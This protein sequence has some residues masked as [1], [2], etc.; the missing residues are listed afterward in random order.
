MLPGVFLVILPCDPHADGRL[1]HK[2][3]KDEFLPRQVDKLS[4]VISVHAGSQFHYAVTQYKQ[5][6]FWGQAKMTGEA[7]TYPKIVHDLSGWAVRSLACGPTSTMLCAGESVISWG[8][9]PAFGELGYGDKEQRRGLPVKTSPKPK[10]VDCLEGATTL[11]VRLGLQFS[12]MVVQRGNDAGDAVLD[13]L[14]VLEEED[15]PVEADSGGGGKGGKAGK[16]GK[17]GK[18]KPAAA[19]KKRA[20]PA[21]KAAKSKTRKRK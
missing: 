21:A 12:V 11:D 7:T 5:T 3:P 15:V 4:K 18:A 13:K 16:D 10:L 9:S 2:L 19:G 1:G 17:A 14:A 20:A 6:Y 8:P